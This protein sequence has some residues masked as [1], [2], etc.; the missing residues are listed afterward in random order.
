[1][2]V[3]NGSLMPSTDAASDQTHRVP[4]THIAPPSAEPLVPPVPLMLTLGDAWAPP[5][6][7]AASGSR[8]FTAGARRCLDDESSGGRRRTR[9]QHLRVSPARIPH[10]SERRE[11]SA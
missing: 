11:G 4:R 8:P 10:A 1:M 5:L 7:M 3:T 9:V 6:A 2:R